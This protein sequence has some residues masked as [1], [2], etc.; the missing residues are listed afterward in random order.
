MTLSDGGGPTG[1]SFFV[2]PLLG[3]AVKGHSFACYLLG[4]PSLEPAS[5]FAFG[6]K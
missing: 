2:F 4:T 3:L 6:Q 1:R 5:I